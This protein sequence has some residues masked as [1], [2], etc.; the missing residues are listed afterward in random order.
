MK[1]RLEAFEYEWENERI[2]WAGAT[3][4]IE[5]ARTMVNRCAAFRKEISTMVQD[6]TQLWVQEF[7]SNLKLLDENFKAMAEASRTGAVTLTVENGETW[8]SGWEL[9]VDDRLTGMYTGNGT[10]I[11]NLMP[12]FR[13]LTVITRNAKGEISQKSDAVVNVQPGQMVN[14]TMTLPAASDATGKNGTR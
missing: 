2:G 12:G 11:T 6:E 8:D 7:Q 1:V 4:T 14:Q 9:Q 10:A 5:Q 3:P 13:K